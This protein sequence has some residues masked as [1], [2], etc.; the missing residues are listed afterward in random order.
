MSPRLRFNEKKATQ[1]A[2][3]LL[4]R[5]VS[6]SA[7]AL[8]GFQLAVLLN[9]VLVEFVQVRVVCAGTGETTAARNTSTKQIDAATRHAR[10][11]E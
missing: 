10:A 1:A 5:K 3:H 8:V 7:Q 6:L 4:K 2:A 11:A 9:C